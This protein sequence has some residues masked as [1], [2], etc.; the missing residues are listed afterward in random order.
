MT[1]S[2]NK[3]AVGGPYEDAI[4]VAATNPNYNFTYVPGDLTITGATAIT[5]TRVAKANIDNATVAQLIKDY[6]GQ[7]NVDVTIK[8]ND[9]GYNTLK[10]NKW[11]AFILPFKTDVKMISDAF[12]YA[13]VDLLN[14]GNTNSHRTVFSLKMDNAEIP[15]N[16]PFIVKV[17]ETIDMENDGV[18]FDDVK[19]EAPETYD[20][21]AVGDAAGNQFI[22]SYTGINGLGAYKPEYSGHVLW[23]SLNQDSENDNDARPASDTGYL[24]Q[25]SAFSYVPGDVAAHEF[26]IEELGGNTTVIRGIN[27]DGQNIS[28]KGLYNMNGMKLNSVPTQKGVYIQNG[29]KIV[30]K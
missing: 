6:D 10:P 12:G 13:I 21:I 23:W 8:F 22:G 3:T 28:A 1:L 14:E 5:L 26:I 17:W 18:T 19:I 4:T 7:E 30:I 20:E 29:K 25:M 16:T 9:P 24:R 27:I 15:A 2:T 11:Y